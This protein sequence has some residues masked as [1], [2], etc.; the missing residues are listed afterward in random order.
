LLFEGKKGQQKT[1]FL[2]TIFCLSCFSC[3]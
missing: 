3:L 1:T 2:E